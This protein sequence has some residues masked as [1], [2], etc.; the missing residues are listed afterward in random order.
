MLLVACSLLCVAIVAAVVILICVVI[1]CWLLLVAAVAIDAS[2]VVAVGA[3]AV[4]LRGYCVA[5]SFLAV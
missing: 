5:Y 2:F 4:V 1:G 3:V